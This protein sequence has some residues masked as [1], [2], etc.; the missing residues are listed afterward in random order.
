V[1]GIVSALT[2]YNLPNF[3]LQ[4]N[5]RS[6]SLRQDTI[7]PALS[8]EATQVRSALVGVGGCGWVWDSAVRAQMDSDPS[9]GVY[10]VSI[11]DVVVVPGRLSSFCAYLLRSLIF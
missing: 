7:L 10:S 9:L 8:S 6:R 2:L 4:M 3:C 5:C 1:H 11:Y